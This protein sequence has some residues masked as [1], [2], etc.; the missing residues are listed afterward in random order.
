[1]DRMIRD[2]Y[3]NVRKETYPK[4]ILSKEFREEIVGMLRGELGEIQEE[5]FRKICDLAFL[6]GVA[7]EEKGF[8]K[9]FKYAYQLFAECIQK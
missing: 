1:M 5:E 8:V 3:L 4:D 2:L 9:G 6:I 7:G